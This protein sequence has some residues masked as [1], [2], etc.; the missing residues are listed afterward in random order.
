MARRG[1]LLLLLYMALT[2]FL[3]N[4]PLDLTIPYLLQITASEAALGWL[5]GVMSLGALSGALLVAA[6]GGTRPRIFTILGGMF[7]NGVMF[8]V[9][10]TTRHPLL[11]GLGLF[12]IMLPLPVGNALFNAIVQVKVP[13]G[14]QGRVFGLFSQLGYLG[15]TLSFLLTGQLVD[16][17]LE[18]TVG[19]SWWGMVAPLVGS[20][21]GS[22]MGL[23]LIVTGA[24]MLAATLA[25]A[26]IPAVRQLESRLPDVSPPFTAPDTTFD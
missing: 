6:W 21:P 22:G 4:G 7:L 11:L 13:P 18:P 25:A 1:L 26:W 16:K 8:L 14:M 2:H 19:G 20:E 17:I 12:L 3:L 10:G 5:M 23:V 15:S 24:I 9:Y